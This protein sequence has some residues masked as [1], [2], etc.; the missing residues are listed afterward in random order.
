MNPVTR[1]GPRPKEALK[2]ALAERRPVMGTFIQIGDP[3]IVEVLGNAGFDFGILDLEHG[4]LQTDSV[5][6]MVRSADR[7][8][9]PLLV[10]LPME[11]LPFVSQ[12]L[13]SGCRGVLAAKVGS[14]ADAEQ[15]VQAVR[16]PPLGDRGACL[17]THA[18]DYGWLEWSDHVSAADASTV[19][20]IALEGP[21][22]I[23]D[24]DA[25]LSV[26]GLDFVFVGIFDLA[27]SLG[28]KPGLDLPEIQDAVRKIAE[29]A[30]RHGVAAGAWAP[31]PKIAQHWL[32]LGVTFLP[33]S[34]DV[35]MWRTLAMATVADWRDRVDARALTAD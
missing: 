22:A 25:I 1:E 20:G 34:L 5:L 18:N 8:G 23:A 2:Q 30:A 3:T 12:F 24:A 33:V 7:T 21:Q 28:L 32:D 13:D 10:R 31:D 26:P 4:G 35:L 17:G 16:Y 6:P 11:K 9:L 27:A 15:V 29:S 19:V 14:V